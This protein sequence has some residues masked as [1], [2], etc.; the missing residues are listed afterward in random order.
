MKIY[1]VEITNNCQFKC[2]Y[3]PRTNYMKR[4]IS[5][6]STETINKIIKIF[7][8]NTIRLH[9]YR[10]SLLELETVVYFIQNIK[11]KNNDIVIEINTNSEYLTND[12]YKKLRVLEHLKDYI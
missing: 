2:V 9:H 7:E 8:G 4:S 1:Q 12:V 5:V 11:N 3:C 6:I 10:E